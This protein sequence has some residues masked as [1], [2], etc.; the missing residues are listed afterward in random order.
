M[1]TQKQ[2]LKDR[3]IN[4]KDG[5]GGPTSIR[6][7]NMAGKNVPVGTAG[8]VGDPNTTQGVYMPGPGSPA[9]TLMPNPQLYQEKPVTPQL[10]PKYSDPKPQLKPD[11]PSFGPYIPPRNPQPGV[12]DYKRYSQPMPQPIQHSTPVK[13]NEYNTTTG[14]KLTPGQTYVNAQGQTIT[15]GTTWNPEPKSNGNLNP[16][17][18]PKY[19]TPSTP[20]IEWGG[21]PKGTPPPTDPLPKGAIGWFWYGNKWNPNYQYKPM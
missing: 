1:K 18:N 3:V 11:Y 15:Q 8:S 5:Q 13:T 19:G 14:V 21:A 7:P 16:G 10:P 17:I 20:K 12:D 6:T 4:A 2:I 9:P